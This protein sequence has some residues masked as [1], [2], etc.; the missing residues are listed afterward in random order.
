MS[1]PLDDLKHLWQDARRMNPQPS[2]D[3][4]HIIK[5]AEKKK[6]SAI[7]LHIG[8]ILV[9]AITLAGITA[10]FRY[11]APFEQLISRIGIGFMVS[12]LVVRILIE[13]YSI[14]LSTN[15]NVSDTTLK[16]S[17]DALRFYRFRKSIH[18]PVTITIIALYTLGFYMLTPEFSL[19][20][21]LPMMIL[22]DLSYI[23]GA[24]IF[25][26]HIRQAIRKEMSHLSEIL[27]LRKDITREP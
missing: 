1:D 13:L 8:T 11:V 3:T 24:V 2:A 5:M 12:S 20:F 4:D 6:K 15:I 10:F 7:Q 18:G 14:Y 25:T 19:Y 9:L 26:W 16:T 23:L 27:R 21:S 17:D 22:I